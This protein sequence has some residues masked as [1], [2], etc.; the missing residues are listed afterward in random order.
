MLIVDELINTSRKIIK[1]S[2][3][4]QDTVYICDIARRQ[5]EAGAGYLNVN[6]R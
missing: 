1:E 5:V 2:M 4:R 3:E 6:C